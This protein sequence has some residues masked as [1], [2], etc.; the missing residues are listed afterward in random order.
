[1]LCIR[2]PQHK[3]FMQGFIKVITIFYDRKEK[4]SFYR[5]CQPTNGIIKYGG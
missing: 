1:M 3:A 4:P 5:H 2:I